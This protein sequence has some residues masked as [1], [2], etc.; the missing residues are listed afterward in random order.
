MW[1]TFSVYFDILLLH[2]YAEYYEADD[3]I[4]ENEISDS[5]KF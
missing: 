5:Y 3:L 4:Y 2:I 1:G